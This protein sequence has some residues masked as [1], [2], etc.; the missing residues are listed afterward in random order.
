[1]IWDLRILLS[2]NHD[3][4][5][6][7][8][9]QRF[10]HDQMSRLVF[11]SNM[12]ERAGLNLDITL[13]LCGRV[14]D[15]EDV[16]VDDIDPRSPEYAASLS[17]I[18]DIKGIR[19]PNLGYVHRSRAEIIQHAQALKYITDAA[20]DRDLPLTEELI[21]ETHRILTKGLLP[22]HQVGQYRTI[23]CG[24][25]SLDPKQTKA[26]GTR[27]WDPEFCAPSTIPG[28]MKTFINGFNKDIK[29]REESGDMDPFYL[30]ADICQDFVAI[31]PF[32]DGNGRMCRLIANAYLIKYAGVMIT[33]GEDRD[34]RSEYIRIVRLSSEN[35]W[36]KEEEAKGELAHL[37]LNKAHATLKAMKAKLG[38]PS[39]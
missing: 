12:I 31:H 23:I 39:H 38:R 13:K 2:G 11:G 36:E 5:F 37:F 26:D 33:I 16:R 24:I 28:H 21:L 29:E 14:F 6:I 1:M 22:D 27:K 30:A 4:G 17:S 3:A 34:D 15:G 10:T 19:S 8:T 35:C 20:L 32:V 9:Y 7:E 25:K 18:A